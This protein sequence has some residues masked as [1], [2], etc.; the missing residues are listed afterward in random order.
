M[1]ELDKASLIRILY[2]WKCVS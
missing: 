1:I 2:M